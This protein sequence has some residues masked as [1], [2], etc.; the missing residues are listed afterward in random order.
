MANVPVNTKNI[1]I[2]RLRPE[3]F[4][5]MTYEFRKSHIHPKFL[6]VY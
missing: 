3:F 2:Y 5:K 4:V 6:Q 1:A